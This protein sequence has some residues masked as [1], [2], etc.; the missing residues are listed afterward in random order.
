MKTKFGGLRSPHVVRAVL[1]MVGVAVVAVALV[2]VDDP[3]PKVLK[4]SYAFSP[5]V[6]RLFTD[7]IKEFN[8][9]GHIVDGRAI[10]VVPAESESGLGVASGS[11][12]DHM[13][14]H[15]LRPT[16]WTPASSL[17]GRLLAARTDSVRVADSVSV[18]SLVQS[19]EV[20]AIYGEKGRHQGK[21]GTLFD[22]V[23]RGGVKFAHTDPNTS[24]SGLS[25]VLAEFSLAANPAKPESNAPLGGTD[26]ER[27][28][29]A[30]RRIEDHVAHYVD[31]ARDF[32][33]EWCAYGTKFAQ[34]V[35][36]QETTY[37]ELLRNFK[38]KKSCTP[39]RVGAM[40]PED[41]DLVADY[42]YYVL[43][44]PWVSPA[45]RDAARSFG[46]W[47]DTTLRERCD[48]VRHYGFHKGQR[49]TP[50]DSRPLPRVPNEGLLPQPR[51]LQE[52]QRTWDEIRRPANVLVVVER[53]DDNFNAFQLD[54]LR[55]IL[56]N[57][58][59]RDFA[60]CPR[61]QDQ[62]GIIAFGNDETPTAVDGP[63][64]Y[65]ANNFRHTVLQLKQGTAYGKFDDA[66]VTAVRH[67]ARQ[68]NTAINTIIVLA[69]GTGDPD[70]AI[71]EI[72]RSIQK[73]PSPPQIVAA[74]FGEKNE[75]KPII[76]LIRASHGRYELVD[77][78][79]IDS[80][81]VTEFLCK[82]L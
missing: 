66:L 79:N 26:A 52:V 40:Y 32:A 16:A 4:I 74:L 53:T 70:D 62:I 1:A 9:E 39:P 17:W 65:D 80:A 43:D 61:P 55:E 82:F 59:H 15:S 76:G 35:Y 6:D 3:P 54:T 64:R 20:V 68:G 21:L 50:D 14:D 36:M 34:D 38:S 73:D 46:D 33:P 71:T 72:E 24:T 75:L 29:R 11:A 48:R 78:N 63:T 42:P 69:W 23:S 27:V 31:I 45:E 19:P 18:A 13:V 58:D 10:E 51:V 41:V 44:A 37:F 28:Q 7:L 60:A 77:P 57:D 47:L 56:A 67:S 5:D 25:A 30:V 12:L 49:C 22:K 8:A 2:S 81:A